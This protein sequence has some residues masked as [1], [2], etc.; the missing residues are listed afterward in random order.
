[1][2]PK[3]IIGIIA[4]VVFLIGLVA[5]S[6]FTQVSNGHVGIV[7]MFGHVQDDGL[8]S[9]LHTIN[10][11]AHVS[12]FN[13]Q[14]RALAVDGEVGT[15]DLQS[16][17]AKVVV[18]YTPVPSAAPRIVRDFGYNYAEVVITPAVQDRLKAVTSHYNAEEL[19]TKREEV[20]GKVKVAVQEAVRER[21]GNSVTVN[22]VVISDFG[23]VS[24]FKTA[25]EKK[26]VAEQE[27]L[28][29][30][31]NADKARWLAQQA[32]EKAK[33]EAAA[34]QAQSVAITDKM[35]QM[36]WIRKWDGTLPQYVLGNQAGLLINAPGAK[37]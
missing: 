19:I 21:S 26:Q 20:R 5:F 7:S 37:Q 12:D 35:I 29:E 25:I 15:K 34:F 23:F 10:P 3:G 4:G 2:Q 9:G 8:G 11:M 16:V 24:S 33:G 31:N 32:I 13:V 14:Q 28:T 6:P 18:N 36:E 1:M 27:A 17:H 30:K 22:D